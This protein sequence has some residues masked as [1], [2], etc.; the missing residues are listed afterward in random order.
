MGASSILERLWRQRPRTVAAQPVGP[1]VASFARHEL[2][3][4]TG[5]RI[6]AAKRAGGD[7]HIVLHRPNSPV[8]FALIGATPTTLWSCGALVGATITSV[9]RFESG[10]LRLRARTAG[11]LGVTVLV[12]AVGA[13][14]LAT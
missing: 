5:M 2:A 14:Y 13:R 1:I 7:L 10:S 8:S 3:V 4:H 12:T 11:D 9:E 6:S